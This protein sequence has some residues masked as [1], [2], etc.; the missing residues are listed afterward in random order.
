[1]SSQALTLGFVALLD[2]GPLVI[3]AEL[4]FA[5]EEGLALTL[6]R[7]PSWSLLRDMLSFGQIAAAQMLAPV[8]VAVALGLGGAAAPL[9]ALQVL[10][11]N[12]TV[13]GVS[14]RLADRMRAAGHVFD[15]RDAAAAGRA[16]IA[17]REAAGGEELRIGVPF[18]F[19]MHAELLYYWLGALGLH[20]PQGLSVRTVPPPQMADAIAADEIDA[21]CVGEPWGSIGVANG[22][23]ELLLPG[24]AIWSFAPEKV[25]ATRQGWADGDPELAGR[26]MRALWRAGKWLG[27]PENRMTASEI[28]A[29]AS[30]LNVSAEVIERALQGQLV[31]SPE[32]AEVAVPHFIEFH[33]GAASFPWRS[34]AVWIAAQMAARTG[35][36]R[37]QAMEAARG[38]FRADLYRRHL[39]GTGAAMPG[40]SEKIEGAL[41]Q[42][43]GAGA[44]EGHLILC[45]NQFFDGREFDPMPAKAPK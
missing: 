17:A 12:G 38:V 35:L 5:E 1:M 15:F 20:A 2:A 33:E 34:Q 16:L 27:Q 19:S 36:D 13:I 3:A 10:S 45:R 43:L 28:L 37:A 39:A 41:A 7:A 9:E 44:S 6:Q 40:A 42:P 21:F 32:G 30:Y 31:I 22:V 23:A 4:G 14:R 26:L 25:L 18:P 24:A 29:R 11:V 8:P